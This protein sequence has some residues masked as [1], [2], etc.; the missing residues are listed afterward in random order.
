MAGTAG[1]LLHCLE[2]TLVKT[3]TFDS[4]VDGC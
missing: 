1:V 2:V 4:S 3:E